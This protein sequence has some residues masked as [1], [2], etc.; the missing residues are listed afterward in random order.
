L[1]H[2]AVHEATTASGDAA[3][4]LQARLET[5]EHDLR[6][7]SE[8]VRAA[9]KDA[10]R[11]LADAKVESSEARLS[12]AGLSCG[13]Q[14]RAD[15]LARRSEAR[16]WVFRARAQT[17]PKAALADLHRAS[18]LNAEMPGLGAAIDQAQRLRADLPC[19][20]CR[21]ARKTLITVVVL[22]AAGAGS[23]Y[24]YKTYQRYELT[25]VS[26]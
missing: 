7:Q 21:A 10:A 26:H 16:E 25:H 20:A 23:Y 6:M 15:I 12:Q 19:G 13:V 22:A 17:N 18:A 4:T 24:G 8:N 11:L 1:I 9:I 14:L 3:A 5:Q 2:Q